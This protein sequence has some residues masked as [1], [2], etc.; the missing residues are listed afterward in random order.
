MTPAVSVP[1][2]E[3]GEAAPTHLAEG[4]QLLNVSSQPAALRGGRARAGSGLMRARHS[5]VNV[6]TRFSAI[7]ETYVALRL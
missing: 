3:A 7:Q 1:Y 6:G 5:P 4:R 2:P